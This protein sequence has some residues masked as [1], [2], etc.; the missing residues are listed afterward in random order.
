LCARPLEMQPQP[1]PLSLTSPSSSPLFPAPSSPSLS[2][3]LPVDLSSALQ[4]AQTRARQK[5][6]QLDTI[7]G[8]IHTAIASTFAPLSPSASAAV[9]AEKRV[10]RKAVARVVMPMVF[11]TELYR[12]WKR[13]GMRVLGVG[14][15]EAG[16]GGGEGDEERLMR[17]VMEEE[18]TMRDWSMEERKHMIHFM[19][20]ALQRGAGASERGPPVSLVEAM[21]GSMVL[22]HALIETNHRSA[23]LIHSLAVRGCHCSSPLFLTSVHVISVRVGWLQWR[24]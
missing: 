15:E 9:R 2:P 17:E 6:E 21:E 10:E 1:L 16:G 14:E 24:R 7:K 8:L 18:P 5:E 19:L 3:S 11:K 23:S 13:K 22:Y 12:R 4:L 20:D